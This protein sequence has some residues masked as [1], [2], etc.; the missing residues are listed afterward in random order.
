M[1]RERGVPVE[2]IVKCGILRRGIGATNREV[3]QGDGQEEELR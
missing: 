1:E 2:K 3:A